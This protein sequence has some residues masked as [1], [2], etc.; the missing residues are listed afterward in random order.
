MRL[1]LNLIPLIMAGSWKS[2]TEIEWIMNSDESAVCRTIRMNCIE[3][4]ALQHL[5][6]M[7]ESLHSW[8]NWSLHWYHCLCSTLR[9]KEDFE[10]LAHRFWPLLFALQKIN[11][12]C[13]FVCDAATNKRC[14]SRLTEAVCKC[15]WSSLKL[16]SR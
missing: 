14:D 9:T 16:L 1:P 4:N 10:W 8:L 3:S 12:I 7:P 11:S 6:S 13:Y 15:S 5:N 2:T